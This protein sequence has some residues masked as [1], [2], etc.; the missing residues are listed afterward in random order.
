MRGCAALSKRGAIFRRMTRRSNCSISSCVRSQRIGKCRRGNGRRRKRNSPSCSTHGSSQH[1]GQPAP[2][3]KYLTVPVI[4]TVTVD[5]AHVRS[6]LPRARYRTPIHQDQSSL[7]QRPGRTNEP[8]DQGRNRQTLSLRRS[9]PVAPPSRR[10]RRRL[11]FRTPSEDPQRPHA[12]R[13]R[14]KM[15]DFRARPIQTQPT[16]SN[17]GTEQLGTTRSPSL[18]TSLIGWCPSKSHSK[19]HLSNVQ[20]CRRRICK[21]LCTRSSIETA[22]RVACP[23]RSKSRR[24]GQG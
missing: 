13:V 16:P 18:F 24:T 21:S 8:H 11:Q 3:T 9:R 14:L 4:P 22:P 17:A 20:P 12:I 10:L 2:H 6:A 23:V 1:D 5:P 15:L 7:D 19:K